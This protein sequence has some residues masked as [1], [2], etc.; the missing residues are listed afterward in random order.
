MY[1]EITVQMPTY[2]N[3]SCELNFIYISISIQTYFLQQDIFFLM[4]Y[5]SNLYEI[6]DICI[7]HVISLQLQG[8]SR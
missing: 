6:C 4:K 2:R 7:I 8:D 3:P 5:K 1:L